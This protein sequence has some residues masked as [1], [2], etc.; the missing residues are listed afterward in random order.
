[1][2]KSNVFRTIEGLPVPSIEG[3]DIAITDL[4]LRSLF[5]NFSTLYLRE[6]LV[7][8]KLLT[9][10]FPVLVIA[11]PCLGENNLLILLI[12][13]ALSDLALNCRSLLFL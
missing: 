6:V 2:C 3:I 10:I 9:G 5:L 12:R 13:K 7:H 11:H 1:M 4:E 8:K